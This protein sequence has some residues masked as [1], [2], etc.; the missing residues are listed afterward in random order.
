MVSIEDLVIVNASEEMLIVA[1]YFAKKRI[2]YEYPRKGYGE[3]NQNHLLN[4]RNGYVGEYCFFEYIHNYLTEKFGNLKPID[5]YLK[6]KNYL[7]YKMII[8]QVQPD[9]DFL[10]VGK[11]VEIKTYGTKV[12]EKIEQV[13]N[14]NLFIDV[15]QVKET[16]VPDIYVQCFLVKNQE[17]LSCVLA[18]Y[19]EGLPSKVC[20]DIPKPAYCIPVKELNPIKELLELII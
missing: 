16:F 10:I 3:Y 8:G 14:Y 2:L 6:V 4:I 12:L 7:A 19:H 20:E 15:E 13:F 18:G 17:K 1:N 9:W 11:S 5:R